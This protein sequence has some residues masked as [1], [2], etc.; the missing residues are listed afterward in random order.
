VATQYEQVRKALVV[1]DGQESQEWDEV[2]GLRFSPGGKH[3]TYSPWSGVRT[4][5]SHV[6]P[7]GTR[8]T[9]STLRDSRQSV[10]VDNTSVPDLD[11]VGFSPDDSRMAY[12]LRPGAKR[13]LVIDGKEVQGYDIETLPPV[14]S[15][16]SPTNPVFSSDGKRVAFVAKK[17]G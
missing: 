8:V 4:I 1:V 14:A 16:P 17:G 3:I 9:H 10:V 13:R 2:R 15:S 11:E 7:N 6:P 12:L 5:E